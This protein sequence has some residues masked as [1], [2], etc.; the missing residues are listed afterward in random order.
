MAEEGSYGWS[1]A[2]TIAERMRGFFDAPDVSA[3]NKAEALRIA[4]IAAERQHRF[5]AMD[6]CRAMIT[7]AINDELG[8]RVHDV[9]MEFQYQFIVSIEE[10][11]CRSPAVRSALAIHHVDGESDL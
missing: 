6:T 3:A 1:Y 9:I 8:Q 4:I 11:N 5:A 10:A 7:S 2:E